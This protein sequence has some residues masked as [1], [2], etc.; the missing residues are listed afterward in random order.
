MKRNELL[1]AGMS[2][3]ELAACGA[4]VN[5]DLFYPCSRVWPMGFAWSS[6]VAQETLL[7]LCHES[8]LTSDLVLAPDAPMPRSL[9]LAFSV[10][11]DDLMIVSAQVVMNYIFLA[12]HN[13][14]AS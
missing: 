3:V 6:A 8:D 7:A 11:T 4:S 14:V 1:D 9:G 13:N 10:A 2:N 12:R 5:I